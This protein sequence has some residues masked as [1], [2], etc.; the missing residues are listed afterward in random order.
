MS[1]TTATTPIF[2]SRTSALIS[3]FK[4]PRATDSC[5]AVAGQ[6]A[7]LLGMIV[8]CS[9]PHL[10]GQTVLLEVVPVDPRDFFQGEY[11]ILSYEFSRVPAGGIPVCEWPRH[12]R[13]SRL[14]RIGK[15]I[16]R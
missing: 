15:S 13:S 9:V 6:I 7:V 11:V 2:H 10:T 1:E 5:V 14:S 4:S 12:A 16:C 8:M 3:W